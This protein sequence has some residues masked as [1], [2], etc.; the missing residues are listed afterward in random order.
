MLTVIMRLKKSY[1][2]VGW[3][4]KLVLVFD[5]WVGFDFLKIKTQIQKHTL[6]C[7]MMVILNGLKNVNAGQHQNQD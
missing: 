4:D 3:G 5:H 6:N 7:S 1:C 2:R